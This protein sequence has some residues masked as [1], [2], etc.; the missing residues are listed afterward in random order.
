MST[1]NRKSLCNRNNKK[2]VEFASVR[3]RRPHERQ[4]AMLLCMAAITTHQCNVRRLLVATE[5]FLSASRTWLHS[6]ACCSSST[7]AVSSKLHTHKT[8]TNE[9]GEKM[10]T[11]QNKLVLSSSCN[12]C[13]KGIMEEYSVR[14]SL[15]TLETFDH[16][17]VLLV[18]KKT[19]SNGHLYCAMK[20]PVRASAP[21][22]V[23][24]VSHKLSTCNWCKCSAIKRTPESL[25]CVVQ[26]FKY[27]RLRKR[28]S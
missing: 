27:R 15:V 11:K 25:N 20:L 17:E 14:K 21:L 16:V 1:F 8:A 6:I 3:L 22:S 4:C 13:E 5:A 7:F 19:T 18:L 24:C 12:K 2:S 28:M 9:N 10:K 23:T 26:R